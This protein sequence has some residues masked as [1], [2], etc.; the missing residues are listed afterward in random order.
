MEKAQYSFART[1]R[2]VRPRLSGRVVAGRSPRFPHHTRYRLAS[3]AGH[4]KRQSRAFAD[5]LSIG[6]RYSAQTNFD[7]ENTI[8]GRFRVNRAYKR[9]E[10]FLPT[11]MKPQQWQ[12]GDSLLNSGFGR[13]ARVPLTARGR[14]RTPRE[15]R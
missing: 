4:P 9:K 10:A 3:D 7:S 14:D 12:I 11:V 8:G 15:M 5:Y 6:D 1:L 2:P 13:L